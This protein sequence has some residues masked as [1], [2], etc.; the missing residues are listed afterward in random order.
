MSFSRLARDLSKV[1]TTHQNLSV[2][3]GD[4]LDYE[5]VETALRGSDA[6][7]SAFGVQSCPF[8]GRR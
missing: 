4:T 5:S 3:N 6:A 8:G 2:V 7:L 1:R